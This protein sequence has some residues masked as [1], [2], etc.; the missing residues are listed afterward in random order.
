MNIKRYNIAKPEEYTSKG[1]TKKRWDNVGTL[2][3]FL[4]DD[5]SVKSR[6]IEIPTISLKASVFPIDSAGAKHA[7]SAS[8]KEE[9]IKPEDI[10]F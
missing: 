9:E 6:M 5:N 7:P 10:P 3:E 2:I 8:D 1:E 4:N